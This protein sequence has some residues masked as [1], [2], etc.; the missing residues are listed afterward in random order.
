MIPPAPPLRPARPFD[1]PTLAVLGNE[2]GCGIPWRIWRALAGA[3]GDP[4]AVGA[5]RAWAEAE[6]TGGVLVLDEG[7]GALA[8]MVMRPASTTPPSEDLPRLIRE[9]V[10]LE[11]RAPGTIYIKTLAALPGE[12]ER[13][14]GRRLI[15]AAE[16]EA[17]AR[18]LSGVSLIVNDANR[19]AQRL[20]LRL[21]FVEAGRAPQVAGLGWTPWGRDWILMTRPLGGGD[22]L[23]Q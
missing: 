2:A 14:H 8:A 9:L 3:E 13:G 5:A 4:W 19:D 23:G 12:R 18:G 20:Y 15:A 11:T 21:G 7:D 16:A 6:E 17:A 1:A 10:A 22:A